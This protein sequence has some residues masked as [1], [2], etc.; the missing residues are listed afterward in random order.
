MFNNRKY[1]NEL[2]KENEILKNKNKYTKE[3]LES[4]RKSYQVMVV[5]NK[6]L[7][8][9]IESKENRICNLIEENKELSQHNNFLENLN[10]PMNKEDVN[11]NECRYCKYEKFNVCE[12][13]WLLDNYNVTRKDNK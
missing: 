13:A 11:C 1:I 12:F 7:Q 10:M 3:Y 8:A 5:K 4:W 9:D 2:I 6:K